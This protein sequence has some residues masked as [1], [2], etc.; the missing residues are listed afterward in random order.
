M[1]RYRIKWNVPAISGVG[2]IE[3][4]TQA[5]AERM[6]HVKM[7]EAME[8]NYDWTWSAEEIPETVSSKESEAAS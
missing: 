4:P 2:I 5:I 8:T 6:A 3:A 1:P 7:Q